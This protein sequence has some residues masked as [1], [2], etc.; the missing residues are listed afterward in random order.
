MSMVAWRAIAERRNSQVRHARVTYRRWPVS[1][2][3]HET[4][5]T[6]IRR[7]DRLCAVPL[8]ADAARAHVLAV[9]HDEDSLYA[10]RH[11]PLAFLLYL[12]YLHAD[13][14]RKHNPLFVM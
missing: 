3:H 14:T 12:W 7:A 10:A 4:T 11:F 1:L 13:S 2:Q 5:V 9:H 6:Q 8:I